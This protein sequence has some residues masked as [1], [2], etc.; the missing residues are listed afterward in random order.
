MERALSESGLEN[1]YFR[2][3]LRYPISDKSEEY[4]GYDEEYGLIYNEFIALNTHMI[5]KLQKTIKEQQKEI[6][7]LK[8]EINNMKNK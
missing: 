4:H 3:I 7:A 6:D 1:T 8:A 5:Q 2:G